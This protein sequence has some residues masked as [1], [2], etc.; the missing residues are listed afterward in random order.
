MGGEN[1]ILQRIRARLTAQSREAGFGMIEVIAAVMIFMVMSIGMAGAMVTMTRLTGDTRSREVAAQL[2]TQDVDNVRAVPNPFNV[3]DRTYTQVV[4]G[5]T[6]TINRV[7]QWKSTLGVT[8]NCGGGGGNILYKDVQVQVTWPGSQ[9]LT[10]PVQANIALAPQTRLNDPS[11]GSIIVSVLGADGSGRSGVTVTITPVN[12]TGAAAVGTV[13][14]TNPDGCSYAFKVNPGTYT[15]AVTASNYIDL[16][17]VPAPTS[18]VVITA[19]NSQTANFAYDQQATFTPKYA[20]GFTAGPIKL[21]DSLVTNYLSSKGNYQVNAPSATVNLFP[22]PEGYAAIAGSYTSSASTTSG[23]LSVD[24]A[25]WAAGKVG[26][27]DMAA[28]A[29]QLAAVA[30]GGTGAIPVPMGVA[31]VTWP[32]GTSITATGVAAPAG[33][34]DPGCAQPK[35]YTFTFATAPATNSTVYLALPYGSW[36]FP[37]LTTVAP[38]T[39]GEMTLTTLTLDPRSPQ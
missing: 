31:K 13:S 38:A 39:Q 24:P 36:A 29:R 35:N 4:G 23:C 20:A 15:V 11:Y 21:P 34:G 33:V 18:T 26:G 16:N 25:N 9:I 7:A 19:G 37:L 10:R 22:I 8:A 12:G 30:A 28:G 27:T 17:Q 32:G 1:V 6:Y 14:P 3:Y 2:A 5:T